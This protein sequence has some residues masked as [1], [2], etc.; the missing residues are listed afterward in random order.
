MV[1]RNLSLVDNLKQ[2][3]RAADPVLRGAFRAALVKPHTT[4]DPMRGNRKSQRHQFTGELTSKVH[5]R[6]LLRSQWLQLPNPTARRR[7]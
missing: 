5:S 1:F 3:D 2:V 4:P 6:H 7:I